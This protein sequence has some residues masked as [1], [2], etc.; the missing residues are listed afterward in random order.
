MLKDRRAA[1]TAAMIL[2]VTMI[3]MGFFEDQVGGG[4]TGGGEWNEAFALRKKKKKKQETM[5]R[6]V[7]V[8]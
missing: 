7:H 4:G 6:L 5:R 2:R 3:G 8:L 1:K